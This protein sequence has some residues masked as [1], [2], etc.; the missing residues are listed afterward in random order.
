MKNSIFKFALAAMAATALFASCGQD[1]SS[2][3]EQELTSD[4]QK[5]RLDE[6]GEAFV[7]EFDI[8]NW[9]STTDGMAA[10]FL[11]LN[12]IE[13]S[14]VNLTPEIEGTDS[15]GIRTETIDLST[16]TGHFT[17]DEDNC[18]NYAEEGSFNDLTL[19][20]AADGH[21]Y[22]VDFT[23]KN[24]GT[25]VM[26]DELASYE[27][28]GDQEVEYVYKRK[29]L[30]L[31]ASITGKFTVDGSKTFDVTASLKYSGPTDLEDVEAEGIAKLNVETVISV[32]AGDYTLDLAKASFNGSDATEDFTLSR[33]GKKLLGA[34]S[35]LKGV[36]VTTEEINEVYDP[37]EDVN[38]DG[39]YDEND[40]YYWNYTKTSETFES[41]DVALDILGQLQVKGNVQAE[42]IYN[43]MNA[44]NEDV[45]T[46]E[47]ANAFLLAIAQY[48]DLGIYYDGGSIKQAWL[49]LVAAPDGDD[50]TI[51][52][53]VNFVDGTS[54]AAPQFFTE[55]NFA[56]TIQ[57]VENLIG[58]VEAY[59]ESLYQVQ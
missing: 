5:N 33:A 35:N 43:A 47:M 39:V 46:I 19:D 22:H 32:S 15:D 7:N 26:T 10:A 14:K 53:M 37:E 41:A 13:G 12:N 8:A 28:E 30:V 9:Q 25:T 45:V 56:K 52:P 36:K 40:Y 44:V 18:I 51:C 54:Y 23:V 38:G 3:S 27:W 48:Y 55:N 34:V 49:S 1:N 11:A 2:T 4:T 57:A 58:K 50:Y 29:Y 21:N 31:P 6:I 17:I 16:L 24:T 20:F 59:I 42:K